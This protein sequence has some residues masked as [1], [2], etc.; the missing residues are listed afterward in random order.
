ME[1][2]GKEK[3]VLKLSSDRKVT[4]KARWEKAKKRWKPVVQNAFGLPAGPATCVGLTPFCDDCYVIPIANMYP[5]ARMLLEHNL[6]ELQDADQAGMVLL[7][8]EMVQ[9]FK[10]QA[11]KHGTDKLFRIHYSG[12]F[13][14]RAYTLAWAEVIRKNP[15]VQFWSY[16]RSFMYVEDLK[17]LDN[18]TLYLSVDQFNV[19]AAKVCYSR[20]P[21]V[22]LAFNGYTWKET[23]EV[24]RHFP[25]ERRGPRCPE[26]TKH[27][28]MV[29]DDGVGACIQCMLCIRGVNNVRFSVKR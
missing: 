6:K 8:D 12:D 2:K 10:K 4:P 29:N 5:N 20:H 26:L 28:P 25:M 9:E 15:D 21:W 27:T 3:M 14:S 17:E 22:M 11:T 18:L 19:E 7:L 23:E 1:T 16:T 24:A 13:W